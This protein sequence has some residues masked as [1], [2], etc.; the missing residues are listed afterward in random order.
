M[1]TLQRIC[2]CLLLRAASSNP[3]RPLHLQH[4]NNT[5]LRHFCSVRASSLCQP[6]FAEPRKEFR[7]IF[8]SALVLSVPRLLRHTTP[9]SE[10]SEPNRRVP[11]G[12]EKSRKSLSIGQKRRQ[13]HYAVPDLCFTNLNGYDYNV[14]LVLLDANRAVST[15][16]NWISS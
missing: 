11:A 12:L 7:S 6:S 9:V 8:Q 15:N 2:Q 14:L 13:N 4:F 10:P 1:A 16:I 3:N 5:A